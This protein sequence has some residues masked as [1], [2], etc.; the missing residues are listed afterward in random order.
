MTAIGP[1]RARRAAAD[2]GLRL[3]SYPSA[4]YGFLGFNLFDR[5]RRGPHPVLADREARR[6]LAM[7]VDRPMLARSVFGEDA[8][9]PP[10][11][12]SRLL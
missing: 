7:G 3:I 12:M 9:A 10:G 5:G 8:K 4:A 11:P 6:A 1:E 2:S